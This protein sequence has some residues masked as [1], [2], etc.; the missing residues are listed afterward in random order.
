M[1]LFAFMKAVDVGLVLRRV[2]RGRVV[3]R[4]DDADRRRAHALEQVVVGHVAGADQPDAGL[5][6][7]ALVELLHHR[8]AL[9]GRHE[10]EQRVGLR[11]LRALQERRVVRVAQRRADRLDD[12]AAARLETA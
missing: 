4:R 2:V 5:L 7:A 1:P 11:V 10:H 9:A 6:Q 8:E 12:L 3:E